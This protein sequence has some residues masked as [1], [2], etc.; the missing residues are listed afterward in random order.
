MAN[1]LFAAKENGE[2]Q[3][4]VFVLN[5]STFWSVDPEYRHSLYEGEGG[6]GHTAEERAAEQTD[7]L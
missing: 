4:D 2:V 3:E 5:Y 6:Y 1:G 7:D